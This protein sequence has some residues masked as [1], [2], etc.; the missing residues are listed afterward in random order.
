[1]TRLRATAPV[2]I[3]YL[4]V[5]VGLWWGVWATHPTNTTT[6]GCG[7]AARFL[8][9]FEWPAFA[10][11]HGHSLWYSQWLFHPG[12]IN[13]LNDTSVLALSVVM[14]P[15][16]LTFGPVAAMNVALTLAPVLSALA[17]F[18][19]LKRWVTWMPA[20]AFGGLV[21]GFSPF[22]ITELAY[23]QLNIAFVAIP[24]LLVIA[25]DELLVRQTLS[26][27][28]VG[29]AVAILVVVQFFVSTE[30]L[31]ITA[32]AAAIAIAMVVAWAGVR[33][34]GQVRAHAGHALQGSATALGVSVAAL[35]YPVWYLLGGPAHLVGP[36][37]SNGAIDQYG[38]S[39]TSFF[40]NGGSGPL[41]AEMHRFGGYQGPP[42]PGLGYLGAGMVAIAVVGTVIW[43]QDRRLLLFG[44]L[45]VVAAALSL[46]PG[47]GHWVP[48]SAIEHVPW[49]GDIVEIRFSVVI[50]LCLA[51]VVAIVVDRSR[52]WV[53][54]RPGSGATEGTG[55]GARKAVGVGAGAGAAAL[56]VAALIP[57]VIT[58]WSNLPLTTQA[59]VLPTWY[60]RVGAH[61]APGQVVLSYPAPFAGVQSSMAWQAV[62]T[63]RFA[64][65]GGGGPKGVA[66]RAGK[67]RDGFNVLFGASFAL[68][69]PPGPTEANLKAVR[70][71]LSLWQV[72][73]VVVPD[74]PG[75]PSYDQG[76]SPAYATGLFTAALGTRPR[77]VDSA[78]VWSSLNLARPPHPMTDS[79][80][81][82]CTTGARA[83]D[84]SHGA[85]AECVLAAQGTG[86]SGA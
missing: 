45:G 55:V 43:R 61:L 75:L 21:Y 26:A 53:Q 79:R 54:T 57:S 15:V 4:V 78:W 31:L 64:M 81:E 63:M 34:P 27:V 36:I 16:T 67:A 71:A 60:Q 52:T 65:A 18:V 82:G 11:T 74:Q 59:V 6:C 37:W 30:V 48:W 70:Q 49:I 72:T 58:L 44:A 41:A 12:G 7:D 86:A 38:N 68:G 2:A 9:F 8:W 84:A 66:R 35:A 85:V 23:N 40:S 22:L 14:T 39:L 56:A 19:L 28:R 46:G 24:P 77:Y 76:R 13:L 3:F 83:A 69:E 10:L 17:M 73:T 29:T 1:M 80:F 25:L 50:T 62:D 20:A 5:S 51:I 47:Y 32:I 33:R 42:L